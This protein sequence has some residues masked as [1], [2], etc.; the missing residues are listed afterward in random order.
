MLQILTRCLRKQV[1]YT[2]TLH[3]QL[4]TAKVDIELRDLTE[5]LKSL[6]ESTVDDSATVRII[7]L[8]SAFYLPGSFVAVS[9]VEY[10]ER[11]ENLIKALVCIRD[12]LLRFRFEVEANRYWTQLLDIHCDLATIDAYNCGHLPLRLILELEK[13]EQETIRLETG[14]SSQVV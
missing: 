11:E 6:T 7:T 3:N 9:E 5:R 4:E 10:I 12:E 13:K 14:A 1:G 2:L 8:V